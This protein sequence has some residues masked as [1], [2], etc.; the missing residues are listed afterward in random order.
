MVSDFDDRVDVIPISDPNMISQSHRIAQAQGILE[1]AEKF[2]DKVDQTEAIKRMLKAMRVDNIE[3][4]VPEEQSNPLEEKI[5][6]LE[7][8]LKELAVQKA[9]VDVEKVGAETGKVKAEATSENLTSQYIGMQ[10]AQVIATMPE[11]LPIGDE[12]LLSAGYEDQNG[13][14]LSILPE[15]LAGMPPQQP[16]I[17]EEQVNTSPAMPPVPP[18]PAN[19]MNQGIETQ[20]SDGQI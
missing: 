10:S 20:E 11:T 1:I 2:P 18:S 14:P 17:N 12:L 9:S 16:I 8:Q 4:L 5:Q 15:Q 6:Q 19:G 7:I 3:T 13:A